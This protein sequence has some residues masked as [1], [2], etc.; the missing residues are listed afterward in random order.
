MPGAVRT[1]CDPKDGLATAAWYA[2]HSLSETK[3]RST[4]ADTSV[5]ESAGRLP[6]E[7]S[8][9]WLGAEA[10]PRGESVSARDTAE[11]HEMAATAAIAPT[12]RTAMERSMK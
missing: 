10:A 4:T 12:A 8:N 7:P 9:P 6:K 11:Q 5:A 3:D 2:T 1:T